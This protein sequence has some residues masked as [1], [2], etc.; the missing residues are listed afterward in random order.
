[1]QAGQ[2]IGLAD[3]TGASVGS[4]LHLTLKRDGATDRGETDYP[5]DILDPT[6]FLLWP[7]FATSKSLE[8]YPWSAG[9]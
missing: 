1:M 3:S 5:K 4:H 8:S 2:V 9:K 7:E 6:P